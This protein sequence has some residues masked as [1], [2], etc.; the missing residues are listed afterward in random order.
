MILSIYSLWA[1]SLTVF[2][3][4]TARAQYNRELKQERRRRLRKRHLKSEFALLQTLSRYS[5]SF[6]S[7]NVGEFFRSWILKEYIEVQEKKKKSLCSRPPENVRLLLSSL[8]KLPNR[9]FKI[10]G[11]DGNENVA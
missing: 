6:S 3:W 7:S 8:R 9:D 5:I 11:R 10:Q 1:G 2:P 4:K